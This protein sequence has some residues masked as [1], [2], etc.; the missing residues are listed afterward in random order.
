MFSEYMKD[1]QV[2][3]RVL[4]VVRVVSAEHVPVVVRYSYVLDRST[5]VFSNR[6][7]HS[8]TEVYLVRRTPVSGK[9]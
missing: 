6:D 3:W 5:G 7:S 2:T 9:K 8:V 1:V 4:L